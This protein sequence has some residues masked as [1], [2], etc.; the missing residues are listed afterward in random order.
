MKKIFKRTLSLALAVVLTAGLGLPAAASDA[1]GEDL[2]E[3]GVLLNKDTELTTNV[4]WSSAYSDLRT[5]HYITYEPN[6]DVTPIVT[7][8]DVLTDRSTVTAMAKELEKQDYRVVAGINGD[9][10]NV[11]TGLPIGLVIT[12]GV[13]RSSDGGYHAIGFKK[14]GEA[15]LGKPTVKVT[16]ELGHF[17]RYYINI[18][19]S[20]R[21][22]QLPYLFQLIR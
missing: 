16:A 12:D 15:V 18:K 13:L 20:F 6:R 1:L 22:H 21:Q 7:Y 9:F 11:S 5:E 19:I 3:Q 17:L 2:T 14:N 4:F 8:G 10:Y